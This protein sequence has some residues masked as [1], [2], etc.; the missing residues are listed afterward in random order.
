MSI[1]PATRFRTPI[2][3][4]RDADEIE[5]ARERFGI[6][7]E[8]L[9][10]ID[11]VAATQA[12]TLRL[13]DQQRFDQLREEFRL[14]DIEWDARY[15]EELARAREKLIDSEI[16]TLLRRKDDEAVMLMLLAGTLQ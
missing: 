14:R 8:V 9:A 7:R 15:L 5:R 1:S 3:D 10:V 12:K 13:D 2:N 6:R 16:Q 4:R 11:D